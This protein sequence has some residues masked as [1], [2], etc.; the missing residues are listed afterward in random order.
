[1]EGSHS[2]SFLLPVNFLEVR[3]ALVQLRDD[4]LD[5]QVGLERLLPLVAPDAGA[6][7]AP[8]GQRGVAVGLSFG[9]Q[10]VGGCA[11]VL[12]GDAISLHRFVYLQ[13]VPA[14]QPDSPRLFR[15]L[16]VGPSVGRFII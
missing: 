6:L 3:V 7:V 5:L 15:K 12:W 10:T 9:L 13:D 4:R 11:C 14:V 8:E 2:I 16:R 1:M